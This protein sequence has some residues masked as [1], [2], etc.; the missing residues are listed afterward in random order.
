MFVL[1]K[2][3]RSGKSFATLWTSMCTCPDVLR[4]NMPLEVA[5]VR[6]NLLG[7][8]YWLNKKLQ[9][10]RGRDN[11]NCKRVLWDE[12]HPT[13]ELNPCFC[14]ILGS[15]LNQGL[16]Q[17]VLRFL[18]KANSDH[19]N[20]QAHSDKQ[21]NWMDGMCAVSIPIFASIPNFGL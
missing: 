14:P 11:S 16:A 18:L 4:T 9:G 17:Q 3:G 19:L 8:K 20:F 10:R 15:S 1:F 21:K 7:N 12:N 5:G 2:A 13:I 6:E